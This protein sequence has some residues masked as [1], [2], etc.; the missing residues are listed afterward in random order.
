MITAIEI[1][2]FK[3]IGPRQRIELKP[4]TLLFGPNSGGKSTI[5]HALHYLREVLERRN[6]DAGET[7]AGGKFVD[8]GGFLTFLHGRDPQRMVSLRVEF[9]TP[10]DAW[11]IPLGTGPGDDELFGWS[12]RLCDAVQRA[13]IEIDIRWSELLKRPC[14]VAYRVGI[15]GALFG[16]IS[17]VP[18]RKL[19]D[20]RFHA[21]HPIFD[22][23]F[24]MDGPVVSIDG[25]PPQR[26]PELDRA[27]LHGDF[28]VGIW[29]DGDALPRWD[30]A[31]IYRDA[32]DE[33][34]EA[35][36]WLDHPI[37]DR[38]GRLFKETG[39]FLRIALRELLYLGPLRRKPGRNFKPPRHPDPSRWSDGLAAWDTLYGG[40]EDVVLETSEWL[41]RLATG[42]AL[43]RQEYRELD[44]NA[45]EI[46]AVVA[47]HAF[48][49]AELDALKSLILSRP[50]QRRLV[51][52]GQGVN[53]QLLPSDV[54]EGLSQVIPVIVSVLTQKKGLLLI[55]QP[56]LH[57]HPAVQVG[58]G[59]LLCP[60]EAPADAGCIRLIETHSEHLLLRLLRRIRETSEG[61]VP[62]GAPRLTPDQLGVYFVETRDGA[63]SVRR[64]RV[65]ETGEFIDRWPHGF[66]EER[67]EELFG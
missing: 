3:G 26:S 34:A 37:G 28:E 42:Y 50:I 67:A 19:A 48:D 66:F 24:E 27:T 54:G 5:L 18:G 65:D 57:V 63:A 25:T 10:A 56:E 30:A 47:G 38:I 59:D 46:A 52:H 14:C 61:T 41:D 17:F 40:P 20:I 32:G 16:E 6:Y 4:L 58:L 39:K 2:N 53:D 60:A 11:A 36:E 45:P 1:E 7:L 22:D 23:L 33:A 12:D 35:R 49:D 62:E 64:L 21:E 9:D 29:P 31:F 51:L 13:F 43:R 55:E 15:N 8:L 44:V